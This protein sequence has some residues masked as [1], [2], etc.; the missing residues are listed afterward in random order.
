[1]NKDKGRQRLIT[2]FSELNKI[3]TTPRQFPS[4]NN[5]VEQMPADAK[6]HIVFDL[7]DGFYQQKLTKQSSLLT[8][9]T[10]SA[11]MGRYAGCW[12]YRS[13]PQGLRSSPD[14]FNAITDHYLH[15]NGA[16]KDCRKVMDDILISSPDF[17]TLRERALELMKRLKA[18]NIKLSRQKIQIGKSVKYVGLRIIEY[19]Q[20]KIG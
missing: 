17:E 2:D 6:Y 4:I 1:M 19:S 11:Q 13:L 10:L 15:M 16:I 7:K 9:F 8:A 3:E 20:T 14:T 12:K 18:G 5:I